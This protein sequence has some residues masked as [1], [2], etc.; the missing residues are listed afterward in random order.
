[1]VAE[2]MRT[3]ALGKPVALSATAGAR[4]VFVQQRMERYYYV[5]ISA[6]ADA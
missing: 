4:A 2:A 6:V 5:L 1:M 3:I